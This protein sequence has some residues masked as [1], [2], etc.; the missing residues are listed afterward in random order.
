[1]AFAFCLCFPFFFFFFYS[2]SAA[3]VDQVSSEQC[4]CALFTDP[5]IPLFSHFF[6]KNM[7]HGT[8]YTFKNYFAIVFSVSIFNFSKNK[9][10]LNRPL[11]SFKYLLLVLFFYSPKFLILSPFYS[12]SLPL[13]PVLL[14]LLWVMCVSHSLSSL[15]FQT[16][17]LLASSSHH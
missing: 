7:S 15:P 10:N 17:T 2:S 3:V 1:M 4:I 5:Q 9:L 14:Y 6:I 12:C 16:L 8:I 13:V 11:I